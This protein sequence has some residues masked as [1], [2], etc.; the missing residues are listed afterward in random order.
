[1]DRRGFII[2]ILGAFVSAPAATSSASARGGPASPEAVSVP[3][4]EEQIEWAQSPAEDRMRRG[5]RRVARR[6][7]RAD[8]RVARVKRR[9]ARRTLRATL[10]SQFR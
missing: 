10:R 2:G 1:M 3:Q 9:T 8:R 4:D 7:R 5:A 6:T